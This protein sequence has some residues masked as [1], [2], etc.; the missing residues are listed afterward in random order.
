VELKAGMKL[1]S[2]VCDGQIIVVRAPANPM[3]VECGG[4]P[5]LAEG[6]EGS[7][8]AIDTAHADGILIGKRY[9]I[10]GEDIELLCTKAGQGSLSVDGVAMTIKGAKP[11]PASD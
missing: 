5:L 2:A 10:E 3:N 4:A 8:A 9:T 1:H 6:E 7:G 11:L